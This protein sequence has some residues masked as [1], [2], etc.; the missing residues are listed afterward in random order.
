V[1]KVSGHRLG[2]AEIE[3]AINS[4]EGIV[5]SA[6][7]GFPHEIKGEA[8]F[9]FAIKRANAPE[10]SQLEKEITEIIVK[11]IG[12][13]ARPEKICFVSDLPKTRSGKIMRRILK[14][15]VAGEEELGD[16][17]TLVNPEI[18]QSLK[19]QCKSL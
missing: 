7:I 16:I 1:I 4:H 18:I 17:S 13:I 19:Q 5:E 6:V 15:I 3:N 8:I 12:A 10:S 9:A 14:K 2:T 11:E